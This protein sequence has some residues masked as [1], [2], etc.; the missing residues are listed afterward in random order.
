MQIGFK[1]HLMSNSG[2]KLSLKA[3]FANLSAHYGFKL[4]LIQTIQF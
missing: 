2:L 3:N 4:K 1:L